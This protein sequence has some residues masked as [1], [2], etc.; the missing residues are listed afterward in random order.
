MKL[1]QVILQ[2][3][4]I[5]KCAGAMRTKVFGGRHVLGLHVTLDIEFFAG[6]IATVQ[7]LPLPSVNPD[8]QRLYAF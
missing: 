8:H 4:S 6:Q 7:T 2:C 1:C 5:P 3:N